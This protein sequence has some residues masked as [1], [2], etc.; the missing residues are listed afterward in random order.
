MYS[1]VSAPVLGFDLVR[2]EG[3]VAVA[4]LMLAALDLTEDDL[5]AIA[6]VYAEAADPATASIEDLPALEA[7][8]SH[9]ENLTGALR[10]GA[11]LVAM[12]RAHE[13]LA[14]LERTS[15]VGRDGLEHFIRYDVFGWTWTTGEGAPRQSPVAAAAVT[16]V[17]GA[18]GAAYDQLP[19]GAVAELLRSYRSRR[20]DEHG[21]RL[22]PNG[23]EVAALV[24]R[25]RRL[26][27]EDPQR[28]S[29]AADRMRG[30]DWAGAVHS[31][32]WA[33]HLADR[34]RET[35]RAQLLA[36]EAL[37]ESCLSVTDL[38]TGAWNLVSGAV[39]ALVVRD[40]LDEETAAGLLR[41]LT[42]A[43]GPLED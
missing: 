36:V 28:L 25:L 12:D 5:P 24:R 6:E 23:R 19:G 9:P 34:I 33:A 31:A 22:G 4:S 21:S 39:Q 13:A 8:A 40:L 35:A 17:C 32:T 14:L 3:G 37:G 1:L 26:E 16:A 18:V 7:S 30:E 27:P 42:V 11:A 15:V 20:A 29:A 10:A 2:R 41:E 38:A 43:L